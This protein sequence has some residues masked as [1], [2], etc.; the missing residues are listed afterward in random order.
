MVPRGIKI[1]K[2][3]LNVLAYTDDDVLIGKNE[4]EM[5]QIL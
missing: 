1:G 3:K 5:R 4:I 2:D